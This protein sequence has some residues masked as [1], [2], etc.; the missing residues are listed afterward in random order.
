M[1]DIANE[2]QNT[3]VD[4]FAQHQAGLMDLAVVC[5]IVQSGCTIRG[6]T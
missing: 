4:D 1:A 5:G 3:K 2:L 6:S